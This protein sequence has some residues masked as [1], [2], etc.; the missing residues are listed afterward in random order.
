MNPCSHNNPKNQRPLENVG[1]W[2]KF[3]AQ[4]CL[5]ISFTRNY[6]TNFK[7]IYAY[8]WQE[9]TCPSPRGPSLITSDKHTKFNYKEINKNKNLHDEKLKQLILFIIRVFLLLFSYNP[10]FSV[11]KRKKKI[12]FSQL[13]CPLIY[14][15]PHYSYFYGCYIV[16]LVSKDIFFYFIGFLP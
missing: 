7:I 5:K 16:D 10:P 4:S 11:P 15:P 14:R 2:T 1:C 12:P 8:C 9:K 3:V 13:D 6:T